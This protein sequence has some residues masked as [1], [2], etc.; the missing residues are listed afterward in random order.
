M[1]CDIVDETTFDLPL[2]TGYQ[3]NITG[4]TRER[5]ISM[6]RMEFCKNKKCWQLKFC[7]QLRTFSPL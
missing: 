7:L 6:L 2:H 4:C 5:F 3:L 1:L